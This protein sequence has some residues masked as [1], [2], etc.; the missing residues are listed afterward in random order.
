MVS[1]LTLSARTSNLAKVELQKQEARFGHC[2]TYIPLECAG[3]RWGRANQ[4][5]TKYSWL[6]RLI[7][8][9]WTPRALEIGKGCQGS[10]N[11]SLYIESGS[12]WR[13]AVPNNYNVP[14]NSPMRRT[15]SSQIAWNTWGAV[16]TFENKTTPLEGA[17]MGFGDLLFLAYFIMRYKWIR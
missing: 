9:K 10:P 5:L 4:M 6:R 11:R 2:T 12:R 1:P 16:K 3:R 17:R 15:L 13:S 7:S 14:A 8:Y